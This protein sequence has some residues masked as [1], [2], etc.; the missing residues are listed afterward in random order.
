MEKGQWTFLSNHGRVF[1]YIAKAPRSTTE[2]ISR[3]VG[4][5]QRGVQKIITE[6]EDAGYIARRKEGRN[7]RYIVHPE[8]PMRHNLERQHAV[9]DLLQALGCDTAKFKTLNK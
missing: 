6:L 2:A 8:L 7:N 9:G 4:L 5:T 3:D 1:E